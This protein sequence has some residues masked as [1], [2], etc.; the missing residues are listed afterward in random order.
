MRNLGVVILA[1][2]VV[3]GV[4]AGVLYFAVPAR[5]LPSLLPGQVAGLPTNRSMRGIASVA[6]AVVLFGLAALV[7]RQPRSAA[8]G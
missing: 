2:L 1:A 4:V 8:Q 7:A 5:S 3:P 6:I